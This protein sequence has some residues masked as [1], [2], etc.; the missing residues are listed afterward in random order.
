M[1][2]PGTPEIHEISP[3]NPG[4]EESLAPA[5]KLLC[6]SA[7]H[8]QRKRLMCRLFCLMAVILVMMLFW[9]IPGRAPRTAPTIPRLKRW[10]HDN[11]HLT[12]MTQD[13]LHPWMNN[14]W[15]RYLYNTIEDKDCYVCSHMPSI[16]VYPTIYGHMMS[17]HWQSECAASFASIGRQHYVIRIGASLPGAKTKGLKNGTCDDKFWVDMTVKNRNASVPFPVF[18]TP[19]EKQHPLCFY[20]AAEQGRHPLGQTSNC[21]TTYG[22]VPYGTVKLHRQ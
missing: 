13:H 20:Q 1:T 3:M 22:T 6:L 8:F 17:S 21:N 12:E 10:T 2:T 5:P 9:L 4:E 19:T 14:A 18:M 7:C 15:Y 11:S 16:S